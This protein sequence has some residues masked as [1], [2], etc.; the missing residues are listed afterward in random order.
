MSAELNYVELSRQSAIAV[1][2][3]NLETR[4]KFIDAVR[5]CASIKD[6]P[7]PYQGWIKNPDTIPKANRSKKFSR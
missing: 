4:L 5:K 7:K 1:Q 2:Y 3:L 6:V